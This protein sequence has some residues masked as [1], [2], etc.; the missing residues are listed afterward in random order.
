MYF[1]SNAFEIRKGNSMKTVERNSH[2][3]KQE[4]III[5]TDNEDNDLKF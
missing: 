4:D 3:V 2:N 5:L 1:S